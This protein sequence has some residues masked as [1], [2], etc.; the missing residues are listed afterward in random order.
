MSITEQFDAWFEGEVAA[1]RLGTENKSVCWWAWCGKADTD[2]VAADL[3][4]IADLRLITTN[5]TR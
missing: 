5:R 1:N 4:V 2:K 3:A